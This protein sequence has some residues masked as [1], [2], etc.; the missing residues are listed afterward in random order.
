M[1]LMVLR[2]RSICKKSKVQTNSNNCV[3]ESSSD[4]RGLYNKRNFG[5]KHGEIFFS[6]KFVFY[7]LEAP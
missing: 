2:T 1:T 7:N 6:P 5:F 4:C 3:C